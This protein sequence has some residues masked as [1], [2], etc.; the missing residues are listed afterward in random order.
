MLA[1]LELESKLVSV[2]SH[3]FSGHHTFRFLSDKPDSKESRQWGDRLGD[4]LEREDSVLR[5][6]WSR[7][8]FWNPA[9]T[10]QQLP[11]GPESRNRKGSDPSS[12]VNDGWRQELRQ[13]ERKQV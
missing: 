3:G 8:S 5:G 7:D 1:V 9:H 13:P 11:S 12:P 2:Q 10:C 4:E 6:E